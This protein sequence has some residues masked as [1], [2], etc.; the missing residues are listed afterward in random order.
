MGKWQHEAMS[1]PWPEFIG[2]I[3]FDRDECIGP[4]RAEWMQALTCQAVM[5]SQGA[6]MED[7]YDFLHANP[8]SKFQRPEKTEEELWRDIDRI[9][10]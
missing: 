8:W 9:G 1:I 2:W 5:N 6:R 4:E 3:E 7:P 10:P